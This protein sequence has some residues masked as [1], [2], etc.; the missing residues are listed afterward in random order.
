MVRSISFPGS[1]PMCGVFFFQ[2]ERVQ[3]ITH[4]RPGKKTATYRGRPREAKRTHPMFLQSR[5]MTRGNVLL[6]FL[7][8]GSS[9]V[10][11]CGVKLFVEA[12]ITYSYNGIQECTYGTTVRFDTLHVFKHVLSTPDVNLVIVTHN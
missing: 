6:L 10:H 11:C 4:V 9:C 5:P 2:D 3:I 8:M 7:D 1:T 12:V